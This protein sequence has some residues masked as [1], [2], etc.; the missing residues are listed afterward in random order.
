LASYDIRYPLH[1]LRVRK[2]SGASAHAAE[3]RTLPLPDRPDSAPGDVS[4]KVLQINALSGTVPIIRQMFQD[5]CR[6][7]RHPDTP[8]SP[9]CAPHEAARLNAKEVKEEWACRY[10]GSPDDGKFTYKD[11]QVF[12]ADG[13]EIVKT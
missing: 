4:V 2:T 9:C 1:P 13:S 5:E 8:A 7:Y 11:A 10:F 12:N 3:Q 6:P